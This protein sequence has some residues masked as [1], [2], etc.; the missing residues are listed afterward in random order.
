MI[1]EVVEFFFIG[2]FGLILIWAVITDTLEDGNEFYS[3]NEADKEDE[4]SG[5]HR[6]S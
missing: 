5:R 6:D 3:N 1:A 4:G 2:L